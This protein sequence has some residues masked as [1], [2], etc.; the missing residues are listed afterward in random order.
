MVKHPIHAKMWFPPDVNIDDVEWFPN[1][2][3][4]PAGKEL[5]AATS[6]GPVYMER[7]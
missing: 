3:V 2:P 1:E 4:T 7:I 6:H 5:P